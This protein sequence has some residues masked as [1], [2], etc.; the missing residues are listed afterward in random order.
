MEAEAPPQAGR[1]RPGRWALKLDP[2]RSLARVW[3]CLLDREFRGKVWDREIKV[4][5]IHLLV[6][7]K[8]RTGSKRLQG[9]KRPGPR[10]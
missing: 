2:S 10:T 1:V 6:A 7:L 8:P 3:R 9:R 4:G 5:V